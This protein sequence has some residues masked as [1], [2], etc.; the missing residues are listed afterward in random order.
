MTFYGDLHPVSVFLAKTKVAKT[1]LKENA[2][3][4]ARKYIQIC[5]TAYIVQPFL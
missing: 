5:H 3:G 2:K 4:S 1:M